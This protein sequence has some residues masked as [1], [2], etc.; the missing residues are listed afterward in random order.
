MTRKDYFFPPPVLRAFASFTTS[1]L[2]PVLVFGFLFVSLCFF[3]G[4]CLLILK[5]KNP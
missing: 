5:I 3:R 1:E 4:W 2:L